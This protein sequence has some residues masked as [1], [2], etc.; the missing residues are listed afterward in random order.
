[1]ESSTDSKDKKLDKRFN[2]IFSG[3]AGDSPT[4]SKSKLEYP[5]IKRLVPHMQ[6]N[7][8]WGVAILLHYGIDATDAYCATNKINHKKLLLDNYYHSIYKYKN[9]KYNCYLVV[10]KD[11]IGKALNDSK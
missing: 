2:I 7:F 10:F 9:E 6:R 5:I 1:M 4:I 8:S 3:Y 11:V